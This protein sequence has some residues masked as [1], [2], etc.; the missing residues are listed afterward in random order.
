MEVT[1]A[2]NRGDGK[3][4]IDRKT[5]IIL[6]AGYAGL[7]LSLNLESYVG[8]RKDCKIILMDKNPYHQLLQEI[9]FVA[10][11]SR[12]EQQVQISIPA[13]LAGKNIQFIQAT[14]KQIQIEEHRVDYEDTNG[15]S[16][17]IGY[18]YL[19]KLV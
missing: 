3:E 13:M 5:I 6:G 15:N 4:Q 17:F 7:F 11:G 9:H 12:T 19:H 10:A 1:D 2:T 8:S 18:D 16:G 14:V